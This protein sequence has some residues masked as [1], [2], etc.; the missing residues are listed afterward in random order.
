MNGGKERLQK[1]WYI[2]YTYIPITSI[3]TYILNTLSKQI[4]VGKLECNMIILQD[5]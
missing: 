3:Y 1:L 4:N 5:L 2:S